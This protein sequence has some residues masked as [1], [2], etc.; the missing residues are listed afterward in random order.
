[1]HAK[2]LLDHKGSAYST[3]VYVVVTKLAFDELLTL[4]KTANCV[5]LLANLP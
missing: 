4:Q 1:M 3:Q 5:V 2:C